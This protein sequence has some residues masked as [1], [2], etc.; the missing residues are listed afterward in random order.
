[1]YLT[2]WARDLRVGEASFPLRPGRRNM[3]VKL[4]S[5]CPY[6]PRD[7]AGHYD[8]EGDLH[9]CAKCDAEQGANPNYRPHRT[10]RRQP[11]VTAPDI[12]RTA[13]PSVVRSATENLA[14]SG[15]TRAEPPSVQRSALTA[16]RHVRKATAAGYVDFTPPDNRRGEIPAASRRNDADRYPTGI[17]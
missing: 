5:R 1:M 9:V 7:L 13:Q 4:C 8:P 16:S 17:R 2:P 12:P 11:C 6:T 14:S 10:H 3:R 15:T